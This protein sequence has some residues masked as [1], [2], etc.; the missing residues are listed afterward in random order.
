MRSFQ[1]F[2]A[3]VQTA[4]DSAPFHINAFPDGTPWIEFYR[5]EDTY[6]LR[7]PGLADFSVSNDGTTVT[8][9]PQPGIS[10]ATLDHLYLNQVQPLASGKQGALTYHAS[11]VD[12][13]PGAIAFLAPAGY[14]KS[15]LAAAFAVNGFSFITDDALVVQRNDTGWM[16]RPSHPSVRLWADSHAELLPTDAVKADAVGYTTK[17]RFLGSDALKYCD[18]ERPLLAIYALLDNNAQT[19]AINPQSAAQAAITL[20]QHAFL[21]NVTDRA[22]LSRYFDATTQ[23]ANAV[24]LYTLD[25][26]RLYKTLPDLVTSLAKHGISHLEKAE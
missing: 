26:P 12:L 7:F 8:G 1:K 16:V 6:L 15:T 14:G 10:Q 22:L 4:I 21:L 3:R 20:S 13:G 11:A 19:L 2:S 5:V 25:Y 18:Q 17:S 23:L 9:T 24:P